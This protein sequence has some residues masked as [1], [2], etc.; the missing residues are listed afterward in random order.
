MAS[1]LLKKGKIERQRENKWQFKSLYEKFSLVLCSNFWTFYPFSF[2]KFNFASKLYFLFLFFSLCFE[3][4]EIES[5]DFNWRVFNW[6]VRKSW[7][8]PIPTTKKINL[9]VNELYLMRGVSPN[10]YLSFPLLEMVDLT[11]EN[12]LIWV[13]FEIFMFFWLVFGLFE[14][15]HGFIKVFRVFSR[16]FG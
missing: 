14:A 2:W 3:R 15:M 12:L 10:C 11:L 6:R 8:T 7:L 5:P 4:K 1:D 9:G 13:D 16:W